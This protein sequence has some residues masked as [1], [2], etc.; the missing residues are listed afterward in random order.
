MTSKLSKKI[1]KII[2]EDDE[3]VYTKNVNNT[4]N[5]CINRTFLNK[6]NVNTM[7]LEYFPSS[8]IVNEY[9]HFHKILKIK[10]DDLLNAPIFN[11]SFNRPPDLIRSAEIGRYHYQT[12]K[13]MD[14]MI[15]LNYNNDKGIFEVIDGI[16]RLRALQIIKE[17][18]SKQIDI[19]N[20]DETDYMFGNNNDASWLYESFILIN[21]RINASM[22]E[23]IDLFKNLNKSN[24]VPELYIRDTCTEKKTIIENI[25]NSWQIKYPTHFSHKNK[26]NRPNVNRDRFIEL[27]DKI[28]KKYNI[29]EESKDYFGKIIEN[30]NNDFCINYPKK[31]PEKIINK[32]LDTGCW[33]FIYSVEE[34][35]LKL[36]LDF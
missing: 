1:I 14:T 30:L 5:I 19:I 33:L 10:V 21:L 26:P 2:D 15:F 8:E 35:S 13:F 36:K 27:L 32:C 3:Y 22:G 12:K 7:I 24:P 25:V 20:C 23:L 6:N 34:I 9:T 28:Y 29:S 18:N 16:H 11:W 31:L 4:Y 17:N